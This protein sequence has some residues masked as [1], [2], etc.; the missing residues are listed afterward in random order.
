MLFNK[1]GTR[2][3]ES[4]PIILRV[5]GEYQYNMY[6]V[7]FNSISRVCICSIYC[8]RINCVTEYRLFIQGGMQRN[9]TERANTML[10]QVDVFPYLKPG[11]CVLLHS[12]KLPLVQYSEN[13]LHN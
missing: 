7:I 12:L 10:Q 1:M 8:Y 3:D 4:Y 2:L 11:A 5:V 13:Y 9:N 6:T